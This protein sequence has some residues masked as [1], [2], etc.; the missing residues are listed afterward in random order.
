ERHGLE[1]HER[2]VDPDLVEILPHMIRQLDEPS[3]PFG[4]G[5]YLVSQ[6]AAERVKVVLGGDG[7]DE[8]FAGY[9][10][11]AG[12]RFVDIY[13]LLPEGFRR[14]FMARLVALIPESFGYKSLAQKAAWVNEMSFHSHGARYAHSLS[15][16][17]FTPAA[18][19]RL[20][21]AGAAR[22][23]SDGDSVAKILRHFDADNAEDLVDRMLFTDLMTRM[24]DHLLTIVDRMSM[25][26][27]LENRSPLVDHRVVE[28]AAAIP[29]RL[30]LK[31]RRLKHILRSVASRYLPPELID[32]PKQ[33][34]S[35][36]IG[37]W[38]RGDLRP[39]L[40]GLLGRSQL[41][42]SGV[43]DGAEVR[44]LLQEHTSGRADHSYR[45]WILLN[46]ELWHSLYFAGDSPASLTDR[47]QSMSAGAA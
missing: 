29:A 42:A 26:H 36:P 2:I 34:F 24:P 25:A 21:S 23:V 46:L 19:E 27:S 5:V 45:L 33:G 12:Q 44:R 30:K 16:L 31:G 15:F 32:R 22:Q 39:C 14:R 35:F 6:M 8:S 20:F 9:D 11:Y 13:A 37:S 3:D 1:G 17:R 43:F 47:I 40:E 18:R 7:G 38:M 28:F 4:F 10:R 41:V